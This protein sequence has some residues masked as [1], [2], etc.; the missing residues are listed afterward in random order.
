MPPEQVEFSSWVVTLFLTKEKPLSK[1][2]TIFYNGNSM[3]ALFLQWRVS[4]TGKNFVKLSVHLQK[5]PKKYIK[6]HDGAHEKL[7]N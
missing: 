2:F 5:G 3:H 4:A 1:Y 7:L 6:V